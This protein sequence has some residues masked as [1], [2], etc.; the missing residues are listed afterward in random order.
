MRALFWLL[1]IFAL[2]VAVALGARL[3]EGYV[4]LVFPPWRL[5]VSLN[6]FVIAAVL[7]FTLF[8]AVLRGLAITFGLPER[9]RLYRERVQRE[10]ASAVFQDAVRLLFEGRFGQALKKGAE[11]HGAGI[12]PG[13][14]ALVAARAA[15]RMRES[16]KQQGWL[17]RA[18]IDDP[19]TEAATL[20]LEAEMLNESRR[21]DEAVTVLK[22][23]QEK[24]G[25]HLAALRLE[26]RARQGCGDW[27]EVLRLARQ[28]EKRD[29]LP[30]ELVREIK[31]QAHLRN[32]ESHG[33]DVIQLVS[34]LRE[35]PAS[36]RSSR[37]AVEGARRLMALDA[38]QEA[39]LLIETFLDSRDDEDWNDEL[40]A[41]YGKLGGGDATGRI[42]R[43]ENW[44]RRHPEDG[45]LLLALGRLCVRQRLWGKAQ[46]YLE[47]SLAVRESREAHL[48]L[49]RLFDQ[50]GRDDDANRLYR[51]SARFENI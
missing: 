2:A 21:F 26:L 37:L 28:L 44:L 5:E 24:H 50:L 45:E 41:L 49:A 11:A 19:R 18:K 47:A 33:S 4:L 27:N 6:L 51:E 23:L 43:A 42:A 17:E 30:P 35:V 40:V 16:G 48:E 13:L 46:S 22:R 29:A 7:L 14:S 1:A 8:Y 31:L 10:R 9:V 3:N 38:H 34:Y 12:A 20:M 39:Q 25:R 32:L 36:E 15:Q